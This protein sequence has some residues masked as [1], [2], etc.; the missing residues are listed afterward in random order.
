MLCVVCFSFNSLSYVTSSTYHT[1]ANVIVLNKCDLMS[2]EEKQEVKLLISLMNATAK[3]VESTYS[4][5]PLSMVL[6][7]GMFSLNDA[8]KND[9]W[10]KEAR[11]GD[12]T[13]ETIE[14]G[15]TSFTYRA[16]KPFYPKK[17]DDTIMAMLDKETPFDKSIILRAKGYM[18][19]A[20]YPDL[21]GDFSLVSL[22]MLCIS[23][24][25]LNLLHH[26]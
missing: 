18:W 1:K 4:V 23:R 11:I 16:L 3:I 10:L 19:L 25:C 24:V 7:T 2:E 6:G 22:F 26:I 12:H 21:Q 20:S 13:P 8:E 9:R 5:V 14:Y 15:I 17:L